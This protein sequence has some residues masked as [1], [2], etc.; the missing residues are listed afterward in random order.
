MTNVIG[1][2]VATLVVSRWVGDLDRD[3]LTAELAQGPT[4]SE[5]SG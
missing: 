5:T 1:N 4:R 2:G 3:R